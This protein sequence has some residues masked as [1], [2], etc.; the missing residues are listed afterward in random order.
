MRAN[1]NYQQSFGLNAL[2]VDQIEELHFASLEVLDR[3]GL[4]FHDDKAV[5]ILKK[6]GARVEDGN[7]VKI[8]SF[9]VKHAL[10][11]V[12]E[13]IPIANRDGKRVMFL[14]KGR[15]YFGTG[16]DT[17]NT[18]D[19]YTGE[20]RPSVKQD[21]VNFAIVSD[22]LEHIDFIMSM[23]LASD[24]PV[25]NS[26]IHEFEAMVL[27]SVK[28]IMY[29]AACA[30]DCKTIVEI[31]EVIAGGAEQLRANPFIMLYDEPSSPLQHSKDALEKMLF[32]A[33]KR[34][35]CLY[36]PTVLMGGTGPVSH[37]GTIVVGNAEF[38]SALVLQ[39]IVSPGTPMIYA[40]SGAGLDMKSMI[41]VYGS[42]EEA[43]NCCAMVKIG[44]YYKLPTFIT[45][46]CSNS[47][48][49]DGQAAAEA[50]FSILANAIGGAQLIHDLG[51][52]EAGLTSS[53]EMLMLCNEAAGVCKK[54]VEGVKIDAKT[55]ALEVIEAVGP[56]GS[57]LTEEHT[58]DNYREYIYFNDLFDHNIYERWVE[59]GS[60]TF[61]TR[62]NKRAR[63]ILETHKPTQLTEDIVDRVK[64]IVAKRDL[65]H[66]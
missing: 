66:D 64:Q 54:F 63:E 20:R 27:N 59:N 15:S 30:E 32:L 34:L 42:V 50:M 22:A 33:R 19:L 16:S 21:T 37:A 51:Y 23:G 60:M 45:A 26:Y 4:R 46:G 14:E 40:G 25:R 47:I 36:C 2:S 53:M 18:I 6:A 17:P 10:N 13:R 44:D 31:C 65:A 9:M 35:P 57:Y 43:V 41:C 8:P 58:I 39:Q 3:V 62:A 55:I 5:E 24:V 7:L 12:P 52:I 49:F 28:P 38:L 48:K 61:E 56:G 29:T 11:T 1:Q